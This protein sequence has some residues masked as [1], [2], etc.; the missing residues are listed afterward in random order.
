[1]RN[2]LNDGTTWGAEATKINLNFDETAKKSAGKNKF[3]KGAADISIGF[4]INPANGSLGASA[5]YNTTGYL[6]VVAG[7]Q[8][9][10]SYKHNIAWYDINKAFIS[11]SSASDTNKTQTAPANAVF[12][13]AT[14]SSVPE[15]YNVFQI[16]V[17]NQQTIFEE[18]YEYIDEKIRPKS[19]TQAESE[20]IGLGTG[21]NLFN[22][23]TATDNVYISS[24]DGSIAGNSLYS[25]SDFI[26]VTPN[27]E[28]SFVVTHYA[29]YNSN[30]GYITGY[31]SANTPV[32]KIAPANAA[33]LRTSLPKEAKDVFQVEIG[34]VSTAYEAYEQFYKLKG[35]KVLG[36]DIKLL[37]NAISNLLFFNTNQIA[38]PAKQYFLNNYENSIYHPAVVERW[39]PNHFF[40]QLESGA[41]VNRSN[42]SR[43]L[44]PVADPTVV[45]NLYNLNF[46]VVSSKQFALIVGD[47]SANNGALVIHAI[48]DSLTYNS[49]Y[50]L[51]A[52]QL[53]P[54]LS[55]SAMRVPYGDA[56]ITVEGRGGWHLN[57]YFSSL[58]ST[59]DSFTPYMHLADPYK[60]YG[61]TDFW[62]KVASGDVGYTYGGFAAKCTQ[63]GFSAATG[64]K[65]APAANDVM[66]NDANARYERW[67]GSAWVAFTAVAGDF[68]FNFAKYRSIWGI[69]QPNIV[70]IMLGT[71][72]FY[73]KTKAEIQASFTAWKA[74][75]EVLIASVKADNPS[76][77]IALLIP[78]STNGMAIA[79]IDTAV[80]N[81][82]L[83]AS[84]F[85]ARQLMISN[86]DSREAE[87]IYVV[88]TGSSID[89]IYGFTLAAAEKPFSDFVGTE[90]IKLQSNS[91]HPSTEGY[92]QMG[93][94]LA[95][96]IQAIR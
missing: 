18:Y 66:Y 65:S 47:Q 96:F 86:F 64:L 28:Y 48:G 33:Y 6:R 71:N 50:L 53:C 80:F 90:T 87:Y 19:I 68:T 25:A 79:G 41:F 46:D 32:R 70:T 59:S 34:A 54:A 5:S 21:K 20:F 89:P 81:Q 94:R 88:D 42:L 36:D 38:L 43:I 29:W 3:N 61:N 76:C 24:V 45:A 12:I 91:P 14:V 95:G 30:K 49:T 1:M 7:T 8:Y 13:R 55:F 69:S 16:E 58:H 52:R 27:S 83:N 15:I 35:V 51:R 74:Q 31:H 39:M 63:I 37:L 40:L 26:P 77:K 57:S 67:D 56:G 84:Q 85:Y 93:I 4:Y 10:L 92:Y 22:K 17:G 73:A 62:K 2:I 75:L 78:P 9:T 60:Y 11:A 44:N 82:K 23:A 72:D